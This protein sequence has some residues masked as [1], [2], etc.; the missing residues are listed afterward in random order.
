MS[1]IYAKFYK[2]RSIQITYL[3]YVLAKRSQKGAKTSEKMQTSQ[4]S[5]HHEYRLSN[6]D[7]LFYFLNFLQQI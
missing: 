5:F 7:F 1:Q 6:A 4:T 3:S 2:K